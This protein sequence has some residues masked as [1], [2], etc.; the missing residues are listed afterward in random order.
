MRGLV[1][2]FILLGAAAMLA[3]G[4]PAWAQTAD[5]ERAV[6]LNRRSAELFRQGRF[7]DAAVL[8]REAYRR[9]PDAVLQYNLGRACEEMGDLACAVAAYET[10]LANGRPTDRAAVEARLERCRTR[11]AAEAQAA[12]ARRAPSLVPKVVAG[13][14]AAGLGLGIGLALVA[15]GRHRDAAAEPVQRTAADRQASAE[16]LMTA[17]NVALVAGGVIAAA[18]VV[19]WIV[20]ARR[21]RSESAPPPRAALRVGPGAVELAVRF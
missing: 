5:D 13:A 19:W 9:R 14:G 15:Q 18:G 20:D 10:Y 6:E 16:S 17:A 7:A 3:A 12:A 2:T 8:L 1:R 11:R 4:G 21:S